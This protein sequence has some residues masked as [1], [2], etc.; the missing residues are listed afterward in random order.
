[1]RCRIAT[2]RSRAAAPVPARPDP[3]QTGL[4]F[5]A[6]SLPGIKASPAIDDTYQ[7]MPGLLPCVLDTAI[8]SDLPGPLL[9]HLPGPVYSPKGVLLM[10]AGTQ[11]I[12]RYQSMGRNG[13]SRLMAVSTYAHTPNGIW[14]PLAGNPM[15]DDLGRSGFAGAVDNHYLERFGGAV[16]LSLTQSGLGILQAAVSKGGNTYISTDS[17]NNLAEQILQS[18]INIAPDL[19]EAPGRDD[20]DLADHTDRLLRQLPD[21]PGA[22]MRNG[23]ATLRH[24]LAPIQDALDDPVT[25]ELVVQRPGEVGVEQHGTW[26]WRMVEAFDF[27][28]LDAIGLLAGSLLSKPF[29]PAHPICMTTLPDGQRCTLLRPPVTAPGTLSMT[30]RIPS[31]AVHTVRDDDFSDLMRAAEIPG[32]PDGHGRS[33]GLDP[34]DA[35]AELL[36]FY[37]AQDWPAFFALAV[38]VRFQDHA[39]RGPKVY[40]LHAPEVE[41]IGKGKARA[42]YEF[43]CKVSIAT[44]ATK[45]KGGQFVLHAKALHG[46]PFDGHTLG[47]VVTELESLTG[48]ETRRIHVDRGYRGHNHRHKFRVWITGQVRRVTRPIRREMKRRAAGRAGHRPSQSRAPHGPQSPQ[49]PQRRSCQRR[50]GRRRLQLRP[51]V[52]L[53]EAAFAR[54]PPGALPSGNLLPIPLNIAA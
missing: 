25:T 28:R 4:A 21:P 6:S 1:M 42:P 49:R 19:F 34:G 10:E 18:Q 22:A 7:L 31:K 24:L 48:V 41:C 16:I 15:S 54:P 13:E 47:P 46:N 52:A 40:A 43:G 23:E 32:R 14:V 27:R 2:A 45:P 9:C 33:P 26:S 29:D 20:R 35:D 53:A 50:A 17:A 11:V 12:G 30:I 51:P 39:K 8:E 44:P 38:R 3:P 37:D 36:A 5:Q